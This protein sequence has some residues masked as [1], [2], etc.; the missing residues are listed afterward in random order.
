MLQPDV[1]SLLSLAKEAIIAWHLEGTIAQWN[2][3]AERLYGYL[4]EEIIRQS[5]LRIL[6][7]NDELTL[8]AE[9]VRRGETIEDFETRATRKD[10][11]TIEVSLTLSPIRDEIGK[12]V[13]VLCL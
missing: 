10:G 5:V 4:A 6:P 9:R 12:V 1:A 13:G 11:R 8:M 7:D 2:G 3:S